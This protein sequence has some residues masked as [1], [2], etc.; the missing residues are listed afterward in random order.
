MHSSEA[1][2]LSNF[3]R[4]C[5]IMAPIFYQD[6]DVLKTTVKWVNVMLMKCEDT[7]FIL[8]IVGC[9][10]C[11]DNLIVLTAT[12]RARVFEL[13]GAALSRLGHSNCM[14]KRRYCN[15]LEGAR[16]LDVEAWWYK[17][18]CRD[19][20][21]TFHYLLTLCT[22]DTAGTSNFMANSA[23]KTWRNYERN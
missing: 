8:A 4:V 9:L 14:Q 10:W 15:H 7:A 3:E 18:V 17:C 23:L 12:Y 19:F 13:C 5:T 20:L 22:A 6:D 16:V 11:M 2:N 21:R 1:E